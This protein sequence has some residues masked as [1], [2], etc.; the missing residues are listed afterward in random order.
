MS[1]KHA[2]LGFLSW[3]P[4]TGY[5]LKKLFTESVLFPWS[6]N[7]NQIYRTLSQLHKDGLVTRQ[8]QHQE[9][10]PSRK[11]YT[12]T[13]DGRSELRAWVLSSPELPQLR[14]PFLVQLA[15]ADMLDPGELDALLAHYEDEIRGQLLTCQE[16]ARRKTIDPARTPREAYL[17]EAM[18][19]NWI[20][21]YERELQ[22][23]RNTRAGIPA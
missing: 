11:I 8:V 10:Y 23:V 19:E 2:I 18:A 1:V 9:N 7:N 14:N 5:D 16:Q 21:F 4:L 12:L 3:K 22:W 17:W 15:W 6:G 13:E 20:T